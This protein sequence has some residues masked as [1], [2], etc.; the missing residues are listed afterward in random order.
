MKLKVC[1]VMYYRSE[2]QKKGVSGGKFEETIK[3]VIC[4]GLPTDVSSI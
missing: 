2:G 1:H 4:H 3:I